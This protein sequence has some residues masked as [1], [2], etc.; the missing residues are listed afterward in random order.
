MVANYGDLAVFFAVLNNEGENG[1][2]FTT[3]YIT[4]MIF[5]MLGFAKM[6]ETK[7]VIDDL[8]DRSMLPTCNVCLHFDFP[9]FMS[10]NGWNGQK[11]T[12]MAGQQQ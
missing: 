3:K 7:Q 1:H 4:Y 8:A 12:E 6:C 5:N 10:L 2:L 9:F 11:R